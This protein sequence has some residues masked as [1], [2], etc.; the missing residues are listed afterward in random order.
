ML[1]HSANLALATAN[2]ALM[3]YTSDDVLYTAFPLFHVNA[4]FTSVTSAMITGA[5]LVLDERFSAS[6]FWD[7]MRDAGRDVLQLHGL[8]ADDP[9]QAAAQR[10]RPRPRSSPAATAAPAR[11][12]CGPPFEERFGVRLHEHYGM[13][14]IGHRHAEHPARSGARGRS[15]ARRR[16]FE[17]RVADERRPRGPGGRG[18][19]DPGAPAAA[20]DHAARVLG[21]AGRDDRRAC[22]TSGSTPATVRAWTRDGF[23]YY[24]DRLTDSIRRARRERLLVRGRERRQRVRPRSWSRPPT[25]CRPSWARTT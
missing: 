8:A 1:T 20:R 9:R 24:V 14:E 21:A 18:R 16:R 10:R 6:R 7:T 5:R 4:K 2:I 13:T 19:R 12:R 22:A 15:A 11:R 3:E 25:A 23:L 17:V